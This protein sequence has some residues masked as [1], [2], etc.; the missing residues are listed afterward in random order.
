MLF[1]NQMNTDALQ[2]GDKICINKKEEKCYERKNVSHVQMVATLLSLR[3]CSIAASCST[4]YIHYYSVRV[5]PRRVS[6]AVEAFGTFPGALVVRGHDW[7]WKDQDGW[8]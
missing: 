1:F 5:Q 7:V 8:P 3:A 6:R 4:C 2:P